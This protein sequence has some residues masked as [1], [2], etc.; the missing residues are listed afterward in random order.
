MVDRD[1]RDRFA[2]LLDRLIGDRVT[3]HRFEEELHVLGF[4]K[5]PDPAI[6]MIFVRLESISYEGSVLIDHHLSERR[7]S[8]ATVDRLR[9]AACFL[10]TDLEYEWPHYPVV[11]RRPD[12]WIWCLAMSGAIVV[13]ADMFLSTDST[14]G[15]TRGDWFVGVALGV[16]CLAAGYLSSHLLERIN[17][18]RDRRANRTDDAWPF[19]HADAIPAD[20]ADW[21]IPIRRRDG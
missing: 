11:Y 10:R 15:R 3:V 20:F 1:A 16:L 21:K 18:L 8:A 2:E 9:R 13:S 17:A 14:T 4:P 6:A 19:L 7:Y 5:H 12:F